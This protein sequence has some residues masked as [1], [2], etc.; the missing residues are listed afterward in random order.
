[1]KKIRLES[2]NPKLLQDVTD[3]Y[4]H[5]IFSH[6]DNLRNIMRGHSRSYH[7][8]WCIAIIP[9]QEWSEVVLLNSSKETALED[10]WNV[11]FK[12]CLIDKESALI[13]NWEKS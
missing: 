9:T 8:Q 3:S 7:K 11:L 12:L 13:K 4:S 6:I 2:E 10:F 5:A 1:M